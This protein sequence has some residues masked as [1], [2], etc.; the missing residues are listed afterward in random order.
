[1]T[2]HIR[3]WFKGKLLRDPFEK[4][5][6]M[7]LKRHPL[8]SAILDETGVWPF[9]KNVFR[10]VPIFM[11]EILDWTSGLSA[12]HDKDRVPLNDLRV[13]FLVRVSDTESLIAIR[14]HHSVCDGIGIFQFM[15]DLMLVYDNE[16]SYSSHEL[17]TLD[18]KLLTRRTDIGLSPTDWFQRLHLD[19]KRMSKFFLKLPTTLASSSISMSSS[20]SHLR[21]TFT[22]KTLST[23]KLHF[24]R[25]GLKLNSDPGDALRSTVPESDIST[26]LE[27]AKKSSV[28]L[29]E[30]MIARLLKHCLDWNRARNIPVR[31]IRPFR[32]NVPISLRTP[33]EDKMPAANFVSMVFLDRGAAI[34]EN[35]V[36]LMKSVAEEMQQV[37]EDRMGLTLILAVWLLMKLKV[38][39]FILR[40]SPCMTTIGLTN[41]GRPFQKFVLNKDGFVKT[42]GVTLVGLDTF[43]PVR[44]GTRATISVNRYGGRLSVTTRYDATSWTKTDAE[45]FHKGFLDRL[46]NQP[47]ACN[48]QDGLI[49]F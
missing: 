4:S 25:T 42:G 31:T 5:L 40:H 48:I 9:K 43:P 20:L 7:A 36:Q 1:M 22:P 39:G 19:V 2:C 46:T 8:L 24:D 14:F 27:S 49:A 30:L 45:R 12:E 3:F 41:L 13:K 15:E 17:P 16:V 47:L 10:T 34:I 6:H 28:T 11:D 33:A 32:M 26:A 35:E 37:K 44:N 38:F 23:A 21:S 29:N 18:P